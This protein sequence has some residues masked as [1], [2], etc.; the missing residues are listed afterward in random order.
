[1]EEKNNKVFFYFKKSVIILLVV[2]VLIL[3]GL[4]FI[5]N[6]QPHYTL[7]TKSRKA[8][9]E[10][11]FNIRITDNIILQDYRGEDFFDNNQYLWLYA[12]DIEKFMTENITGTITE[13]YDNDSYRKYYIG[14][15][16][17]TGT[18]NSEV[19]V[20]IFRYDNEDYYSI[21]LDTI[22]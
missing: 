16:R 7:F 4:V 19:L 18:D 17:Y 6:Y 8:K 5:I 22:G 21:S 14:G 15:F 11:I 1:M 10:D 2:F 13:K 12:D 3:C 20:Q 9:I